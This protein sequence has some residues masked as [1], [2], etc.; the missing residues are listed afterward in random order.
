MVDVGL[1]LRQM[2]GAGTRLN[3]VVLDACRNNPF[4]DAACGRPMGPCPDARA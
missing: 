4:G 2:E 3:L 1:V